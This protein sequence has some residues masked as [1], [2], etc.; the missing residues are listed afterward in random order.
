M[1]DKKRARND[2]VI[3][4]LRL[5]LSSNRISPYLVEKS[6]WLQN[7]HSMTAYEYWLDRSPE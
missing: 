2:S 3:L 1:N 5:S 4:R 6:D 7:Y